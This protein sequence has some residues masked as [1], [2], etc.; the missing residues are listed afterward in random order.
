MCMTVSVHQLQRESSAEHSRP[1]QS[2][3]VPSRVTSSRRRHDLYSSR[4]RAL[5]SDKTGPTNRRSSS[6]A[7]RAS[8]VRRAASLR[9]RLRYT[10][11]VPA[12]ANIST[13]P[14]LA[15]R[16]VPAAGGTVCPPGGRSPSARPGPP[17]GD[18]HH[19]AVAMDPPRSNIAPSQLRACD[20]TAAAAAAAAVP[21]DRP[22]GW[23]T[24]IDDRRY[25]RSRK[26]PINLDRRQA[27]KR[28]RPS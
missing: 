16:R 9:S 12:N 11:V 6:G 27:R 26:A 15:A 22:S 19:A 7:V 20:T 3:V 21:G 28:R 18:G 2:L 24:V 10:A 17:A 1:V 4:V 8:S 5:P 23:R 14:L 13:L 25:R